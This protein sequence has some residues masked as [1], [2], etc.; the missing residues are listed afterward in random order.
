[1]CL[2]TF[3]S[4]LPPPTKTH[5]LVFSSRTHQYSLESEWHTLPDH[6]TAHFWF[7]RGII[8]RGSRWLLWVYQIQINIQIHAQKKR[9][10]LLLWNSKWRYL[11]VQLSRLCK[12][13]TVSPAAVIEQLSFEAMLVSR[14]IWWLI[15]YNWN[16]IFVIAEGVKNQ[17]MY[18]LEPVLV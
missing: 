14:C 2:L 15:S 16:Y 17:K 11:L 3:P 1:M 8:N 12:A 7:N 9:W 10:N 5:T 6:F 4:L 13:K 18:H